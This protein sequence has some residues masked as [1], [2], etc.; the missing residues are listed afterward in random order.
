[1]IGTVKDHGGVRPGALRVA[2]TCPYDA[3]RENSKRSLTGHEDIEVPMPYTHV[4]GFLALHDL[5]RQKGWE[6]D[7]GQAT[8]PY[9]A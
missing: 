4:L 1:M 3:L 9:S 5:L 6:V 2:P 7:D 8:S